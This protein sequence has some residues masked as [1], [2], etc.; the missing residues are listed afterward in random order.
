MISFGGVWSNITVTTDKFYI[1]QLNPTV[2]AHTCTREP[3]VR[4]YKGNNPSQINNTLHKKIF[5]PSNNEF[6]FRIGSFFTRDPQ[7]YFHNHF[8]TFILSNTVSTIVFIFTLHLHLFNFQAIHEIKYSTLHHTLV[9]SWEIKS[10][11]NKASN[12]LTIRGIY[13]QTDH[14]FPFTIVVNNSGT[15]IAGL[16]V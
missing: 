8:L 1:V 15:S 14:T 2:Q 3:I 16:K 10:G 4:N 6:P 13:V 11:I 12:W 5:D 7:M 9:P